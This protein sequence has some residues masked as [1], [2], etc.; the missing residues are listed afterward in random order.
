MKVL[1][2][3][4]SLV[5]GGAERMAVQLANELAAAGHDSYLCATRKEGLL[6]PSIRKNV[7][8]LFAAKK[9]K[10]GLGAVWRIRTFVRTH[11][12]TVLHAHSTSFFTATLVKLLIPSIKIVWHDHYGNAE[13]LNTRS[14]GLLIAASRFFNGVIVVNELLKTWSENQLHIREVRYFKNFV[15][16]DTDNKNLLSSLPGIKGQRMVHLANLRLQKDHKTLLAAFKKIHAFFPNWT[17]LLVGHDF[18][19]DYA[20]ELR[21]WVRNH[22]LSEHVYFLGTRPDVPAILELSSLG[23]LSSTSEGLP[24][25]LLE[26]GMAALPVIVT[27]VGACSEVVHHYGT[28]VPAGNVE[29]FA[30]ALANTLGAIQP[31]KELGL[32]F[33][34]HVST[35]FGAKAYITEIVRFYKHIS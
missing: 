5:A 10:I 33:K 20:Q 34:C 18:K 27:D 4:D 25:A 32:Q 9:G 15:S 28:V 23:V 24:V 22:Q 21:S 6:K 2:L 26:Y 1:Q 14:A 19:D 16:N 3:I 17:L 35:T 29:A 12:I 31:A 7:T 8:Y 30:T 11:K 13:E